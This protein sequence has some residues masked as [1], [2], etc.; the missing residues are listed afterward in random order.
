MGNIEVDT[1]Q[2]QREVWLRARTQTEARRKERDEGLERLN[3]AVATAE[4]RERVEKSNLDALVEAEIERKRQYTRLPED[5]ASPEQAAAVEVGG[6]FAEQ[7]GA[8]GRY[9][10]LVVSEP[11]QV[12]DGVVWDP[13]ARVHRQAGDRTP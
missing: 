6:V 12:A 9:I 10:G 13:E 4:E 1:L 3:R 7:Q 2:A 11:E 5:E 8:T